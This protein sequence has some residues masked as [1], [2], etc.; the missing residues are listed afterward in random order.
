M[1]FYS[2]YYCNFRTMG[3]R[4]T[5]TRR[6]MRDKFYIYMDPLI[7]S[8]LTNFL[9]ANLHNQH[10]IECRDF[11]FHL[12]ECIEAYGFYRGLDECR[13]VINDFHECIT[14]EKRRSR[15]EIISGEFIR[16]VEAGERNYEKVPFLA[17]F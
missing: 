11:E 14:K 10:E 5:K 2:L 6:E 13:A 12:A 1:V 17:F 15:F 3:E 16:Q 7:R 9:S 4:N 8:P